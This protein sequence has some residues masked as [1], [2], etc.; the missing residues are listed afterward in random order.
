MH[1]RSSMSG[2]SDTASSVILGK[3]IQNLQNFFFSSLKCGERSVEIPQYSMGKHIFRNG[4]S[5]MPGLEKC[6]INVIFIII[7]ITSFHLWHLCIDSSCFSN[8]DTPP[9]KGEFESLIVI[10]SAFPSLLSPSVEL[11]FLC[12]LILSSV[13]AKH[14]PHSFRYHIIIVFL[15]IL[16]PN[17]WHQERRGF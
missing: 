2:S 13:P 10:F 16:S 6:S 8:F 4:F 9:K 15:T 17:F 12:V 7:I 14:H 3:H 11:H 5:R 1:D